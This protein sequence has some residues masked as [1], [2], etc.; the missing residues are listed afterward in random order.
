MAYLVCPPLFLPYMFNALLKFYVT[1]N[2]NQTALISNPLGLPLGQADRLRS[3]SD[4]MSAFFD[5]LIFWK[6]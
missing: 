4:I 5:R 6:G 2:A 3:T 1:L